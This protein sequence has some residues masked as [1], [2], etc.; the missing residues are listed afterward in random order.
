MPQ[1]MNQTLLV[2]IAVVRRRA[3]GAV[4]S[5]AKKSIDELL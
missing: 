4:K 5:E 3:F 1:R 2:E